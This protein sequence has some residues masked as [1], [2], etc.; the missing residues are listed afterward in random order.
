MNS[1]HVWKTHSSVGS[2]DIPW[3][4]SWLLERGPWILW[5]WEMVTA[6]GTLERGLQGV[7]AGPGKGMQAE[8][9]IPSAQNVYGP[10]K[11]RG[12]NLGSWPHKMLWSCCRAPWETPIRLRWPQMYKNHTWPLGDSGFQVARENRGRKRQLRGPIVLTMQWSLTGGR[13]V[14]CWEGRQCRRSDIPKATA[15]SP[16]GL[17]GWGMDAFLAPA[18]PRLF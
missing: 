13:W 8:L 18:G 10:Q 2:R 3:V 7:Q 9:T 15:S 14:T 5:G 12:E 17:C 11:A 1:K 4:G 16:G 6:K